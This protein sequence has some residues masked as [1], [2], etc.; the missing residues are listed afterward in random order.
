MRSYPGRPRL[1]LERATL[2][3]RAERGVS[4]GRSS[5]RLDGEGPNGR[6]SEATGDLE[7][8]WPQMTRQLELPLETEGETRQSQR[9]GEAPT[10][11]PGTVSTGLNR[12]QELGLVERERYGGAVL[13]APGAAVATCVARRFETL[14]A[15]ARVVLRVAGMSNVHLVGSSED[16]SRARDAW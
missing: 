9:S 6:E 3:Q 15:V 14:K 11:A 16:L 10:A 2:G 5:R 7:E 13:T 1:A 4:R 8:A 12:L